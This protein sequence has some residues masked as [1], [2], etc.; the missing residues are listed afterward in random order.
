MKSAYK[1]LLSIGMLLSAVTMAAQ[2][3]IRGKVL[4]P[5]GPLPGAGVVIKGTNTGTT[6]G[7]DGT[8]VLNAKPGDIL[9]ISFL[10]LNTETV[11]VT[12]AAY[13]TVTLTAD[14]NLLDEIVVVGYDVQKKVNLTGAVSSISSE[15]LKNK[16]VVSSSSALQGIAAGVTV[17]TQSG[18]P[19]ADG[20]MIRVRGI[21]TFGGSSAAPLVLIDGV[22]GSLDAVDATQIDKISV[23]KD[24]ASSS[25]YGSRAA[26]GVI[27]VTTKR[28]TKGQRS[29]SY[30]GY[31]GWQEPTRLPDTVG[32]VDYMILNKEESENDGKESIY[33]DEY[34]ANYLANHKID[35]DS[36]PITN[37]KDA[38]LKGNGFTHNHNLNLTASG[39]RIRV[40]TSLG[41]LKQNGIIKATDYQR[42]NLRNNMDV[43]ISDKLSM[44]LDLSVVY[45]QRNRVKQQNTIFNY[46]NT[47]DPLILTQYS[48]GYYAAMQ[49]GSVNILAALNGEGGTVK[50]DTYRVN[51]AMTLSYKPWEWLTIEGMAAPRFVMSEGHT[52]EKILEFASD[53]FG[54]P[55]LTSNTAYA[56]LTESC[57]R[58]YYENYQATINA[59]KNWKNKHDLRVL[60]GA[61]KETFSQKTLSAYRQGYSFPEYETID[62]GEFNEYRKNG[63]A[64]YQWALLSY[65]GRINYNFKERY[66]VEANIRFDGSSRF[67][68]SNRWG[69][70]PSFSAAWRLTE[71][72]WMQNVKNVLSEAKIRASYGQLGNQNISSSYYPFVSELVIDSAISLGGGSTAPIATLTTLANEDITWETSTMYDVGFDIALW[73]KLNITADVYYKKTEDILMQLGIPSS[74]GLNAPYQNAGTVRN[75][76]WEFSVG[77]HDGKGDFDW[78]VDFNISDVYN[79]ILDMKGTYLEYSSGLIRNMEGHEVNSIYGLKSL[80][81][82]RSQEEADEINLNCPQYGTLVQP[83][84]LHYADIAGAKDENGNDIP[85]GKVDEN[86]M[87][88]IGSTIPRYTYGV[89]LSFGWKGLNLSA[90]FQGVGKADCLLNTY[91]IYP[92][93]QGGTYRSEFLDRF[94]P[95]DESTWATAKYPRLTKTSDIS[96]KTSSFWQSSAAYC[97]LKNLQ[98]SYTLPK[99]AVKKLHVQNLTIFGNATNLFTFTNFYQGYD[100][101]LAYSGS[102]DGVS[103]GAVAYNYPQVRTFTFGIDIKF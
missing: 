14:E 37:W 40:N 55:S 81:I 51:G 67:A 87:T 69:I 103:L 46:M 58:S 30:R 44:K 80:G 83:G 102:D 70:F 72:P 41:Y 61:S 48:T 11:K 38:I 13:Y 12:E 84:D 10:G 5:E 77:Y 43:E 79:K 91:Y 4:D 75:A 1:L 54:T 86:D 19:G 74:I 89:T 35:P 21:G 27:L 57:N 32:P 23:L 9:E 47:R 62:A 45:G 52:F 59:H 73:N 25:I 28:G 96:Y 39:D 99:K 64:R 98:L 97:R 90:F 29:V 92:G 66:L 82:I 88:I 15:A 65:F 31:V 49:G 22:E 60:I 20:G 101:E 93:Y 2:S 76:G 34:I 33:T 78:G 26:N 94:N 17:T 56:S 16:P 100:P 7:A 53:P 18:A 50:N 85:D 8:F 42:F 3:Q 36:Y 95:A 68:K 24:A 6:T 71:E 63:G